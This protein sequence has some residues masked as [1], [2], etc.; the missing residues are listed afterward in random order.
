METP[1]HWEKWEKEEQREQ[2]ERFSFEG[3]TRS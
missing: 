1:K 2:G 3:A